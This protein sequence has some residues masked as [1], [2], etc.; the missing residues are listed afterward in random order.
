VSLYCPPARS[1]HTVV[2]EGLSFHSTASVV[3]TRESATSPKVHA[4]DVKT[5]AATIP[6]AASVVIARM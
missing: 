5:P 6:E 4:A 2:P 1:A 3:P